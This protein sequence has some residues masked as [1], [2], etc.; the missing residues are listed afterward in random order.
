MI[1]CDSDLYVIL[2]LC[3]FITHHGVVARFYVFVMVLHD[4]LLEWHN[5]NS[6]STVINWLTNG[7]PIPF[8]QTLESFELP[9]HTLS[10]REFELVDAEINNLL[11]TET[12]DTLDYKLVCVS[13]LG[14][15]PKKK[16]QTTSNP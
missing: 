7:V 6:S 9:N 12:I 10:R 16:T 5:I 15:V 8:V 13:P 4:C 14:V 2:I 3:I 11:H 1:V